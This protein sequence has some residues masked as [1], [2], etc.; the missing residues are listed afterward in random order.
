MTYSASSL[1]IIS[2]R[3]EISILRQLGAENKSVYKTTRTE[4]YPTIFFAFLLTTVVILGTAY[5]IKTYMIHQLNALRELYPITYTPSYYNLLKSKIND[6]VNFILLLYPAS[7]PFHI[8]S[9]VVTIIGTIIPTKRI[10]K[11]TIT[12]GIRK[13]TD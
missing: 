12:E 6:L 2:A 11:E 1:R 7:L 13:D 8:I 9:A 5:G 3:R 10:L 4:T